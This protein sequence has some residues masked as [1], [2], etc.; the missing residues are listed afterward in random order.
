MMATTQSTSNHLTSRRGQPPS[1]VSQRSLAM[2]TLAAL[3]LG[4][5][6]C[7][8]SA[9]VDSLSDLGDDPDIAGV[10]I[11]SPDAI[12]ATDPAS[13]TATSEVAAP[14]VEVTVAGSVYVVKPG[15]TL[16]VIASQHNVTTEA[17]AAHNSI[18]NVNA[19]SPGQELQIPSV[20]VAVVETTTSTAAS[21]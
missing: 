1:A 21:G 8:R 12:V 19:I 20:P 5:S 4:L 2:I 7:G 11:T 18:S 13:A 6:A 16:G 9:P 10:S 3:C 14:E 17:L 15:D